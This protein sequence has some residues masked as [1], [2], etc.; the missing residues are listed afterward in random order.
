MAVFGGFSLALLAFSAHSTKADQV[1]LHIN[2]GNPL[3]AFLD[4]STKVD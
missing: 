4:I 1:E 3:I 2:L